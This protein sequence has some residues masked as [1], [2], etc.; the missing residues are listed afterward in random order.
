MKKSPSR[1]VLILRHDK[2]K[3]AFQAALLAAV[4]QI[5][6]ILVTTTI[7]TTTPELKT[8]R[9]NLVTTE[10]TRVIMVIR[11][12]IVLIYYYYRPDFGNIIINILGFPYMFGTFDEKTRIFTKKTL[13]LK[14]RVSII[15]E[16][17]RYQW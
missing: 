15:N 17:N 14:N 7:T 6:T 5:I 9:L 16:H 12:Q 3:E 8:L 10:T 2:L 11:V 1:N 13:Y 4:L